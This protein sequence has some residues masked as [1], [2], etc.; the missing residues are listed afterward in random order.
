MVF[1]APT[2]LTAEHFTT[3]SAWVKVPKQITLKTSDTSPFAVLWRHWSGNTIP[4]KIIGLLSW[5][6]WL[7]LMLWWSAQLPNWKWVGI[8]LVTSSYALKS[9]SFSRKTLWKFELEAWKL[10]WRGRKRL[11]ISSESINTC[12]L[13]VAT[14]APLEHR[15]NAL[16]PWRALLLAAKAS[17]VAGNNFQHSWCRCHDR[18][19][20]L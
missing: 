18:D 10:V 17:A 2:H 14:L 11:F 20:K 9:P 3:S 6:I 12:T 5:S 4:R 8:Y 7:A 1:L 19:E 13:Y 16:L 15:R